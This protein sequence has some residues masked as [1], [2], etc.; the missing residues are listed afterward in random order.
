M[1]NNRNMV[2]C[3]L[4]IWKKSISSKIEYRIEPYRAIDS[5]AQAAKVTF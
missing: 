5:L 4:D 1:I 2:F 3:Y